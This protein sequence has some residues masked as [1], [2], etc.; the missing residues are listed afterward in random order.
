MIHKFT[1]LKA[2]QPTSA[3]RPGHSHKPDV[4]EPQ[5]MDELVMITQ[6]V[7]S[8]YHHVNFKCIVLPLLYVLF[9]DYQNLFL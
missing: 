4:P 5:P 3:R 1:E 8:L 7:T 9:T 2:V 6:N